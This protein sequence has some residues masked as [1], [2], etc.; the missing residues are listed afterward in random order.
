MNKNESPYNAL[1]KLYNLATDGLGESERK[2]AKECADKLEYCITKYLSLTN[3]FKLLKN[4]FCYQ[5]GK[6]HNE[7]L[8]ACDGCRWHND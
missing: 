5:C 6:Y 7:H 1:L 8:G 3:D 4:E 2:E